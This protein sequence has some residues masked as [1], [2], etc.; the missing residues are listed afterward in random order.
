MK[1]CSLIRFKCKSPYQIHLEM[2]SKNRILLAAICGTD[3]RVY[4]G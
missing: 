1:V 3:F 4:P 2:P